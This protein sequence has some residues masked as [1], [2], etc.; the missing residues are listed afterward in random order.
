MLRPIARLALPVTCVAVA[1]AACTLDANVD[2]SSS[3]PGGG[4]NAGGGGSGSLSTGGSSASG[5]GTENCVNGKDDDDNGDAD[6]ADR[7][8]EGITE[9]VAIPAG[10]TLV[11]GLVTTGDDDPH[12]C[13]NGDAARRLRTGPAGAPACEPCGCDLQNASCS[14]GQ[15][16]CY[17]GNATC[18]GS[19]DYVVSP[20]NDE[21][22]PF[23]NVPSAGANTAS[24]Q[25]TSPASVQ[26]QGVC[27]A[28]GGQKI[29]EPPFAGAIELCELVAAEGESGG[30][31]AGEACSP[32][33]NSDDGK[34]CITKPDEQSCPP[35]WPEAH[36]GYGDFDDT[37][38]CSP[39]SCGD[40]SCDDD[41]QYEIFD[42]GSCGASRGFVTATGCA[43]FADAFDNGV[44]SYKAK[45]ATPL[46]ECPNPTGIGEVIGLMAEKICCR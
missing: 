14:A 42:D 26:M 23:D 45:L 9:C 39:C 11:R 46:A 22:A 43:P 24:C 27:L 18:A 1:F 35:G 37:R 7:G 5:T 10:W 38:D 29:D 3:G 41:G 4:A 44:A 17:D 8:C 33:T 36:F 30:C 31:G 21:C 32:M 40:V 6:C 25:I 28:M 12:L 15:L 20:V 34:V 2:P 13:Q 19:A 16:T